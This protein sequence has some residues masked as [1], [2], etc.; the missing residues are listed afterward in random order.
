[1][2]IRSTA[3]DAVT[4][5]SLALF[6]VCAL[7]VVTHA[8]S[9]ADT[10]G[11]TPT[12]KHREVKTGERFSDTFTV[13]NGGT[14]TY[15]F[16]VYAKPY[17]V[18]DTSY[19]PVF[20][21]ENERSDAYRWVSLPSTTYR[22]GPGQKI[23]VPYDVAVSPGARSGGHYGAIFAE[24]QGVAPEGQTAVASNK[25]V[26]M[27]L[28]LNVE[29]SS[30]TTGDV[31]SIAIPFYQPQAPLV[32]TPA[33]TNTGETDFMATISFAVMDIAGDVKYQ[34]AAQ[35]TMLPDTKRDIRLPWVDSPWFGLYKARVS[36]TMLDETEVKE[37]YVIIAPRWIL[38]LAGLTILLGAI[39]VVRRK[40]TT[41][42]HKSH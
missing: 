1:M 22:I 14:T 39:D 23:Q 15:D 31:S 26:G 24:A 6:F 12:S 16:K 11:L 40:R 29:G 3:I 38:F 10:I 25:S 34:T 8:E 19:T 27:L 13:I 30:I 17:T 41:T 4:G 5:L 42:K 32:A 20:S 7:P 9:A 37:S 18:K 2:T 35:Y 28:Y 33:I 21:Q 36:V